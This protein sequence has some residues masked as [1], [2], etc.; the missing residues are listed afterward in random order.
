MTIDDSLESIDFDK[1]RQQ[2]KVKLQMLRDERT[3]FRVRAFNTWNNRLEKPCTSDEA[4]KAQEQLASFDDSIT[5]LNEKILKYQAM[6]DSF[7]ASHGDPD[8]PFIKKNTAPGATMVPPFKSY[9]VTLDGGIPRYGASHLGINQPYKV[10]SDPVDRFSVMAKSIYGTQFEEICPRL[11]CLAILDG[12]Q[13]QKLVRAMSASSTQLTWEMCESLFVNVLVTQFDKEEMVNAAV[14][15]GRKPGEAYKE[16]AWRLESLVRVFKL[17][18][19][20]VR[21]GLFKDLFKTTIDLAEDFVKYLEL[22]PGPDDANYRKRSWTTILP[23]S[24]LDSHP[25]KKQRIASAGDEQ[26]TTRMRGEFMCLN[27]CGKNATHNTAD[28][29]ICGLCKGRGPHCCELSQAEPT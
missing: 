13:S 12:D 3:R 28:C 10:A 11:L 14:R 7:D 17:G 8:T 20:S 4:N 29:K 5:A 9:K 23:C 15:C 6:M 18:R 19:S 25:V 22:I 26:G 2:C 21:T 16:Y 1:A 24:D 27:G